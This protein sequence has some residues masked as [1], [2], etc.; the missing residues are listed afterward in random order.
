MLIFL[1]SLLHCAAVLAAVFAAVAFCAMRFPDVEQAYRG[2]TRVVVRLDRLRP[3]RAG[4]PA[5]VHLALPRSPLPCK[6]PRV[7]DVIDND[8]LGE[9]EGGSRRGGG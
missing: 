7:S 6:P 4:I 2:P 5:H 3:P 1:S 8:A 9:E